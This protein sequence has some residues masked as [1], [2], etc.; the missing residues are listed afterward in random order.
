MKLILKL[1]QFIYCV[2]YESVLIYQLIFVKKLMFHAHVIHLWLLTSIST[3]VCVSVDIVPVLMILF[4]CNS[5][6][7]IANN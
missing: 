1:Y 6:G 2:K 4:Y 5:L 7:L 3:I